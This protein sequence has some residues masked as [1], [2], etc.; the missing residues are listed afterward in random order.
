MQRSTPSLFRLRTGV[1]IP[2][3]PA[4]ARVTTSELQLGRRASFGLCE[5]CRAVAAVGREGGRRRAR[6]VWNAPKTL[7]KDLPALFR[8]SWAERRQRAGEECVQ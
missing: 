8:R 7:A 5:S 3:P 6:R 2:P 1:R 4:F